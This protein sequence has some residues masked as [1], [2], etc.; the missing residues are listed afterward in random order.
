MQNAGFE[1]PRIS[2]PRTSVNSAW[3]RP[4]AAGKLGYAMVVLRGIMRP[5]SQGKPWAGLGNRAG[6]EQQGL[7]L[8]R[9][10]Y[11]GVTGRVE[12]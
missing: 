10:S 2:V 12:F 1:L 6:G 8:C 7:G 3:P 11:P 9:I 5:T 4:R